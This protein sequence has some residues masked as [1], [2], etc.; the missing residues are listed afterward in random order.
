ML[1]ELS[2]ILSTTF[3]VNDD[4]ARAAVPFTTAIEAFEGG[5]FLSTLSARDDV[6]GDSG[7]DESSVLRTSIADAWSHCAVLLVD[8]RCRS[9]WNRRSELSQIVWNLMNCGH[10]NIFLLFYLDNFL[11][12]EHTFLLCEGLNRN[13]RMNFHFHFKFFFLKRK[14]F[15]YNSVAIITP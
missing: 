11:Q 8:F 2:V 15:F 3:G 9:S 1:F 4:G 10:W 6:A 12:K 7:I 14:I 5:A 13:S